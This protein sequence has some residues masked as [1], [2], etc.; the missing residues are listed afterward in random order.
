MGQ[1]ADSHILSYFLFFDCDPTSPLNVQLIEAHARPMLHV[2]G[3]LCVSRGNPSTSSHPAHL[4]HAQGETQAGGEG[5][6]PREGRG[7]AQHPRPGGR[8]RDA[9]SF[10]RLLPPGLADGAPRARAGMLGAAEPPP[11]EGACAAAGPGGRG[12]SGRWRRGRASRVRPRAA[13]PPPAPCPSAPPGLLLCFLLPVRA[14]A[15]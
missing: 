14:F 4:A 7:R 9:C 15:P 10:R 11:G 13:A 1:D 5:P 6:R 2:V 12:Q 8:S 3:G